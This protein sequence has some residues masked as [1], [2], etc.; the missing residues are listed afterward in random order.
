MNNIINRITILLNLLKTHPNGLSGSILSHYLKVSTRTIRSDI[1]VLREIALKYDINIQSTKKNGYFLITNQTSK[2][3]NLEKFLSN[4]PQHSLENYTER[5]QYVQLILIRNFLNNMPIT[6]T[7]LADKLYIS[8]NSLKNILNDI[9]KDLSYYSIKIIPFKSQGILLSGNEL[10]IRIFIID[11]ICQNKYNSYYTDF[12]NRYYDTKINDILT[13]FITKYNLKNLNIDI[14]KLT[15]QIIIITIREKDKYFIKYD[16]KTIQ[17]IEKTLEYQIAKKLSNILLI[18]LNLNITLSDVYFIAQN[19]LINKKFLNNTL[20]LPNKK[21]YK[22]TIN[23]LKKIKQDFFIDFTNDKFLIRT[24]SLHLEVALNRIDFNFNIQ[25]TSLN[26]IKIEYPFA[27]QLAIIAS[28]E[29]YNQEHVS[30]NDNEIGYI[31]LHFA[32]ALNRNDIRHIQIPKKNIILV[33]EAGIG[34]AV[35]LKENLKKI[36]SN[37]INIIDVLPAYNV[38]DSILNKIDFIFSTVPL[39]NISSSTNKIIQINSILQSE[40][41]KKISFIL[42]IKNFSTKYLTELFPPTLFFINKIYNNKKDVLNFIC[43]QSIKNQY[44]TNKTKQSIFKREAIS[45][46]NIGNLV[47]I[48]HPIQT[49]SSKS[50]ISVC[51]LKNPIKWDNNKVQI[52]FLLNIKKQECILWENIFLSIYKY[53]KKYGIK[54]L[55]TISSYS[56][57]ISEISIHLKI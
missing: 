21:I 5:I 57:F 56:E 49:D 42:D 19:L 51:I 27:F 47:A 54:Q 22:L 18:K 6:Q 52:I 9:K 29:I 55:L 37:Q 36:F 11:K 20:N 40:D 38:N 43:N 33:C 31:A 25:N 16:I 3:I 34:T 48:P 15:I 30:F 24:L 12:I 50:F 4:E 26:T 10:N 17:Q 23:I 8:L 35:L 1:K 7:A 53:I 2:L 32:A 28:Q 44:I 46:T 41:I 39:N 13:Q 14:F 45:S